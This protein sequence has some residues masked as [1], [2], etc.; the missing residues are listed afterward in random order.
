MI[1]PASK[2]SDS[3]EHKQLVKEAKLLKQNWAKI[4]EKRVELKEKGSIIDVKVDALTAAFRQK[5][6]NLM[7]G[8]VKGESSSRQEADTNLGN[9]SN[10]QEIDINT[11]NLLVFES[12][13]KYIFF[14]NNKRTNQTYRK[15]VRRITFDLK[16]NKYSLRERL[17]KKRSHKTCYQTV[18]KLIKDYLSEGG[19]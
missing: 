15:S 5:A 13:E 6:V 16:S 3:E 8:A 12:V 19:H 18:A 4:I 11:N 17:L 9:S 2:D 1:G 10:P 14:S 7:L